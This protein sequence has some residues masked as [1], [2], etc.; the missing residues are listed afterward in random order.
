MGHFKSC[1]I[2]EIPQKMHERAASKYSSNLGSE[3]PSACKKRK[4]SGEDE[5]ETGA[6][7]IALEALRHK[8][9]EEELVKERLRYILD[10]I[11]LLKAKLANM[12]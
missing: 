9:E 3:A 2:V 1:G 8:R 7:S 4:R 10:Y 11:N 6:I 12:G 5:L